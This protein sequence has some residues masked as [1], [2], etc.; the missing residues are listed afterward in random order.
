MQ[1]RRKMPSLKKY[2]SKRFANVI[3]K[4]TFV[5]IMAGKTNDY[6]LQKPTEAFRM[7]F[8]ERYGAKIVKAIAK[9]AEEE[10]RTFPKAIER[11][12]VEHLKLK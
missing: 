2:F 4:N 10:D 9:K 11:M 12:L 1:H 8:S 3:I 5:I 7:R 6:L